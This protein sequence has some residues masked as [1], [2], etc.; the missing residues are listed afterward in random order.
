MFRALRNLMDGLSLNT[1][2]LQATHMGFSRFLGILLGSASAIWVARCLGP[3]G[4]GVSGIVIATATQI[5]LIVNLNQDPLFV[6]SYKRLGNAEEKDKLVYS[7]LLYRLGLCILVAL[8]ALLILPFAHLP[9]SYRGS[10]LAGTLIV[11]SSCASP[12]WVLQAQDKMPVAYW[13]L[14]IPTVI[15]SAVYMI[16]FRPG[17]TATAQLF[18]IGMSGVIGCLFGWYHALKGLSFQYDSRFWKFAM[19]KM[20]E[21]RWLA[22]TGLVIYI[23]TSC[24]Q[25]LVGYL[26]SIEELGKYR[27]AISLING[28]NSF[29]IIFPTLFY[30]K[31]IEWHKNGSEYL[32]KRQGQLCT[33]CLLF[34]VPVG[35]AIFFLAKPVY[36]LFYGDKFLVAAIPFAILFAS[37]LLVVINGIYAWGLWAQD[38]D[39]EL[40]WI[41]TAVAA[42]SLGLNVLLIPRYGMLAAA[43][44]NGIS[45][46]LV[47]VGSIVLSLPH[48]KG[49]PAVIYS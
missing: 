34:I 10:I 43:I 19:S 4:L 46:S 36:K 39:K 42:T 25:P 20:K 33:I 26:Y 44:T 45:E 40:L 23:Y 37:K 38:R 15:S 41:M 3:H 30:P 22:L 8:I 11:L 13:V 5:A 21:G 32:W 47:A 6:R 2:I 28:L 17:S 49:K 16:F 24:E 1:L 12:N 48:R 35:I 14:T 7:I 29:L 31:F 27:S 18:V 9:E